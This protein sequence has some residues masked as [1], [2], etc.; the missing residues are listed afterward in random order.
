M[1]P[2]Q[3]SFLSF[4]KKKNAGMK[5]GQKYIVDQNKTRI[6]CTWT[7]QKKTQF[8]HF[9][10]STMRDVVN[11]NVLDHYLVQFLPNLGTVSWKPIACRAI[12][13]LLISITL[14]NQSRHI[15]NSF[16]YSIK[17]FWCVFVSLSL[18]KRKR[19]DKMLPQEFRTF[20]RSIWPHFSAISTLTVSNHEQHP[21]PLVAW[22]R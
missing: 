15:I 5:F 7:K 4:L 6:M 17:I 11:A 10:A 22:G 21:F 14:N 2:Q 13:D 3:Q 16:Q 18:H 20:D 9:C 12:F 19:D 1:Q 8:I